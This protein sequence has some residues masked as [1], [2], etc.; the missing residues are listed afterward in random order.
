MVVK[1]KKLAQIH[2]HSDDYKSTPIYLF[3]KDIQVDMNKFVFLVWVHLSCMEKTTKL[4]NGQIRL[5]KD[6][7]MRK[8]RMIILRGRKSVLVTEIYVFDSLQNKRYMYD[9]NNVLI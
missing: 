9:R 6:D 1:L 8:L 5:F 2:M 7:I 3:V 4:Y